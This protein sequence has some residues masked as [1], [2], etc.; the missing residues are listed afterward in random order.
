MCLRAAQAWQMSLSMLEVA[1]SGNTPSWNI[2]FRCVSTSSASRGGG[3]GL[4]H[5]KFKFFYR[6]HREDLTLFF[7]SGLTH[8]SWQRAAN[9]SERFWRDFSPGKLLFCFFL[10]LLTTSY[11]FTNDQLLLNL[12][13]KS[14][15]FPE[16]V[17]VSLH[18]K[19]ETKRAA[20]DFI[21][22]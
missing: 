19:C 18:R 6:Q 5:F 12:S 11:R 9:I 2:L 14:L 16:V 10:T 21:L 15:K 4:C 17:G 13:L 8:S 1:R 22:T 3:G 7:F 20:G